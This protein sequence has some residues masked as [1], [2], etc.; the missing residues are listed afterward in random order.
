MRGIV[1]DWEC[2][3]KAGV[4]PTNYIGDVFGSLGGTPDFGPGSLFAGR[5]ACADGSVGGGGAAAS[6]RSMRW[7]RGGSA[8]GGRWK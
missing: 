8:G 7:R 5:G 3:Y 2:T 6:R 4:Q 1:T